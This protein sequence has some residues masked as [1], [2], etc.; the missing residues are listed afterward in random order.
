[1]ADAEQNLRGLSM[2]LTLSWGAAGPNLSEITGASAGAESENTGTSFVIK[3]SRLR[4]SP[5]VL[6]SR[7]YSLPSAFGVLIL[8]VTLGRRARRN[9]R[10]WI[11]RVLDFHPV[12]AAGH[13]LAVRDK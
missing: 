1:M 8:A 13:S 9:R 11:Y 4:I 7:T 2:W 5:A 10:H 6:S 3:P 12:R